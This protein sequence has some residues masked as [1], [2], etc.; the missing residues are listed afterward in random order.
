MFEQTKPN[1]AKT[2]KPSEISDED[3]QS[4]QGG[5]SGTA[6]AR[7]GCVLEEIEVEKEVGSAPAGGSMT[8]G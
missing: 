1:R 2:G 7:A 6:R 3:L 5:R 8:S 4:V